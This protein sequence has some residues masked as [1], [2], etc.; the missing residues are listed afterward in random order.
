MGTRRGLT[1]LCQVKLGR[2]RQ[3][4][5]RVWQPNRYPGSMQSGQG[6]TSL[7]QGYSEGMWGDRGLGTVSLQSSDPLRSAR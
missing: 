2:L 3:Q 1:E 5:P 4:S 6:Y 7:G